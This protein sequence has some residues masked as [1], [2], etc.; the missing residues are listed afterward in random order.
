MKNNK[1]RM[2]QGAK[3][4][5]REQTKAEKLL[6]GYLN[7]RGVGGAKFRRQH[8]VNR[9][10]LDF[11]CPA[12]KLAIEIDG[13]IHDIQKEYDFARQ[14]T[15]EAKGIRFIRFKNEEVLD[16]LDSVIKKIKFALSP[17]PPRGEGCH[18]ATGGVTG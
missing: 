2:L 13:G 3:T 5:R 18:S 16:A 10:I 12:K 8:P 17:S 11:Y 15:L 14:Q 4:L 7:N 1:F 6:W 9:F